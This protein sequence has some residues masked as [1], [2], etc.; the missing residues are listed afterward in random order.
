MSPLP[1][2][3]TDRWENREEPNLGEG[4]IYWHVLFHNEPQLRSLALLA[5]KKLANFTGLHMTPPNWLHMTVLVAGS[6]NDIAPDQMPSLLDEA[7]KRLSPV[8]AITATLGKVLYHPEAIMLAVEPSEALQPIR[9]AIKNA[10]DTVTGK[11]DGTNHRPWVPHVTLCYSTSVQSA[12]PII[13]TLGQQL[14]NCE[15]SINTVTL[16]TQQGPERLWDWHPY[17][18]VQLRP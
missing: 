15:V 3:L 12:E 6:T 16:V 14:P 18:A 17:G 2:Q 8:K 9:E 10:T 13:A 1:T 7:S 4:T 5:Q 11:A